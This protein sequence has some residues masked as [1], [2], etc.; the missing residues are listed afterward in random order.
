MSDSLLVSSTHHRLETFLLLSKSAKGVAVATLIKD[1]LSAPNVYVF[2]ELLEV[3]NV[4]E[5]S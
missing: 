2:T 4:V 1:V 5:V 3:P